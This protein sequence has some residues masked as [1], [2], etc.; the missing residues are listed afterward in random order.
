MKH[1]PK[2]KTITIEYTDD[3]FENPIVFWEAVS[4]ATCF[5]TDQLRDIK[6]K[7]H[8]S[9][10]KSKKQHETY[11]LLSRGGA[12]TSFSS[13]KPYVE[14]Y[15]EWAAHCIVTILSGDETKRSKAFGHKVSLLNDMDNLVD[16]EEIQN[17]VKSMMTAVNRT[18]DRNLERATIQEFLKL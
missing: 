8:P 11:K 5:I 16:D 10:A 3:M 2:K 12:I 6:D 7:K 9:T 14:Q 17:R 13:F 4:K 18:I 15:E 1:D